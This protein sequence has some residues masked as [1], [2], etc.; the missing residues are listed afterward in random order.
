MGDSRQGA[1]EAWSGQLQEL[2]AIPGKVWRV[3]AEAPQRTRAR[4][5]AE[6]PE[7]TTYHVTT[8]L[9]VCV[10]LCAERDLGGVMGAGC[11]C[12]GKGMV[13]R[14]P[15]RRR[16]QF[17]HVSAA[18]E[19]CSACEE[20]EL[21]EQYALSHSP[22]PGEVLPR[23][24]PAEGCSMY[25][26]TEAERRVQYAEET[27]RYT[28]LTAAAE[29]TTQGKRAFDAAQLAHAHAHRQVRWRERGQP[30]LQ[31]P[32]RKWWLELLHS[33][34]LNAI[35]VHMKHSTVKYMP[36]KRLILYLPIILSHFT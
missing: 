22:Q 15:V 33:V 2:N 12:A 5:Q 25:H 35:K 36:G 23:P 20:P 14:Y 13:Q 24:C 32:K 4:T 34:A 7:L 6:L 18:L 8:D 16:E 28:E 21:D 9:T 10:D 17:Q 26:G 11:H 1:Q 27:A 19:W 3:E 29:A 31:V 30:L